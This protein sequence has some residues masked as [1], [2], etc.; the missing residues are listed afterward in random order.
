MSEKRRNFVRVDAN[1]LFSCNKI[2]E[3]P[4]NWSRTSTVYL[5]KNYVD[6]SSHSEHLE[7]E[8]MFKLLFAA[9]GEIRDELDI[10]KKKLDLPVERLDT[11]KLNI[12]GSGISFDS[13]D[14]YEINDLVL[15]KIVLPLELPVQVHVIGKIVDD[16][17]YEADTKTLRHNVSFFIIHEDD[18]ELIIRY[19]F[20][21]QR[22]LI[23]LKKNEIK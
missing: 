1:L 12:S 22:E 21:R 11:H 18:R 8:D 9:V 14:D 19:T 4:N 23:N 13:D 16:S 15:L 5:T 2:E 20:K 17:T 10:I 3:L 6:I 7:T